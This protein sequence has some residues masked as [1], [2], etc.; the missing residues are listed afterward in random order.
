MTNICII[1]E[2]VN[3]WNKTQGINPYRYIGFDWNNNPEYFGSNK[4]LKN[5]LK[6]LGEK[7]FEKKILMEFNKE[8]I[9]NKDLRM[10]ESEIL[11][12]LKVK[13]S[14]EFY[15]ENEMYSPGCGKKGMKMPPRSKEHKKNWIASRTGSKWTEEQKN[16]RKGSGNPMFGRKIKE[17][18]KQIWKEMNRNTG[19]NNPQ[20]L[21]WLIKSSDGSE[22]IIK[23]LK[24]WCRDN[25]LNYGNV[26][27]N[28]TE[29]KV[30]KVQ[31]D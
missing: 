10:K 31:N 30:E 7:Y 15:N 5:D 17:S 21:T 8:K 25:N 2:T 9:S 22:F 1:Y 28:K 3:I 29:W 24:K 19:E 23:S 26:W 13:S 20:S 14:E 12:S 11:K 6:N 27:A 18:T 4:N 16:Q